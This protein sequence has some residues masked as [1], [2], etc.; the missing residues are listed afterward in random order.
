ML[1]ARVFM[2]DHLPVMPLPKG[3]PANHCTASAS[4]N[5]FARRRLCAAIILLPAPDRG[6]TEKFRAVLIWIKAQRKPLDWPNK[7]SREPSHDLAQL[8]TE[9]VRN[10]NDFPTVWNTVLKGNSLIDGPP[11]SRMEGPRPVLEIRLIT[12]ERLIFD[13]DAKKF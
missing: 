4:S 13:G 11:Q 12:G 7:M 8:C 5:S 6:D 3:E 9:L 1:S 2:C 10:G